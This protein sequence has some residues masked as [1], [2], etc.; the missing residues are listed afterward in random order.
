MKYT[1]I[2]KNIVMIADKSEAK[3]IKEELIRQDKKFVELQQEKLH[4]II[5]LF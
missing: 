4:C 2:E 1:K 3:M 5:V